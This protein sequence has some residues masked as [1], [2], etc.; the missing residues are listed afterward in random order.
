MLPR[1][2]VRAESLTNMHESPVR[3]GGWRM[4]DCCLRLIA[5]D[6]GGAPARWL[7][8]HHGGVNWLGQFILESSAAGG[9]VDTC[10]CRQHAQLTTYICCQL[11]ILPWPRSCAKTRCSCRSSSILRV[12]K[13]V[14]LSVSLLYAYGWNP[15]TGNSS[16]SMT[17]YSGKSDLT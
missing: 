4:Y 9:L 14:V 17:N 15:W 8:S 3:H 5:L 1:A 10:C 2:G 7:A 6:M 16:E 12:C 13:S 11:C